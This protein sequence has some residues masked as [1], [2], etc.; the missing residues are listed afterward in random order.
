MSSLRSFNFPVSTLIRDAKRLQGTLVDPTLGGPVA[1]RLKADF[2]ATLGAQIVVVE[3]GG[4]NQSGATGAIGTLTQA[5]AEAYTELE[6]LMA[7]ARR[8]ASLAFPKNDVRLRSEFQVG[9]SEP[10]DLASE[11]DRAGKIAAACALHAD[12]LAERGWIADD[13]AAL[14]T[15][16]ATLTGSDQ[17]QEAAKDQKKGM[18]AAR[19]LAANTLYNLCLTV[20]NAA[21]LAYPNTQSDKS[22]IVVEARA[23]FL[24]DEFPPRGGASA[25]DTPP[26]PP[27]PPAT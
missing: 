13:T 20:Q 18:T 19:N 4:I 23:R 6:R 21:R 12:V 7:S 24:L 3:K 5:Q 9:I 27:A 26:A 25:G 2:P 22:E 10:R 8:S 16:I 14:T 1:K 15:A 11:L 17:T